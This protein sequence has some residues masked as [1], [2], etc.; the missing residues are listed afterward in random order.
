MD[1]VTHF[2]TKQKKKWKIELKLRKT[3]KSER[4]L[5]ENRKLL[6]LTQMHS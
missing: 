5:R 2:S 3:Q 1:R 6:F 4:K